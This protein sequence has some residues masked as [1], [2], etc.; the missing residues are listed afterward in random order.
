MIKVL[1]IRRSMILIVEWGDLWPSGMNLWQVIKS[2]PCRWYLMRHGVSSR[3]AIA[4]GLMIAKKK[5]QPLC[6]MPSWI[7]D[8]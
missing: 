3:V 7:M 1:S 4:Y 6:E 8:Q 2:Y 5:M